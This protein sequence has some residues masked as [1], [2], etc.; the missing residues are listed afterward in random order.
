MQDFFKLLVLFFINELVLFSLL[1]YAHF[2]LYKIYVNYFG[3]FDML[4][5]FKRVFLVLLSFIYLFHSVTNG[6]APTINQLNVTPYFSLN[7]QFVSALKVDTDPK[8]LK[9]AAKYALNSIN[10]NKSFDRRS[11][12]PYS[13]SRNF[14]SLAKVKETLKF[15]IDIIKSDQ[16][17]NS[18]PRVLDP[19]FLN[20]Y[21]KFIKWS[22]DRVSAAKHDK[23]IFNGAVYL[24]H[25]ATFKLP[26]SYTK[27]K[28]YLHALYA[29][30]NKS[31]NNVWIKKLSKQDVLAGKLDTTEYKDKARP[32]FWVS[33]DGLEESL[34]QGSSIIK[35]P[36]GKEFIVSVDKNNGFAYDKTIKDR[37]NQKRYWYF[38]VIP[39][40][41]KFKEY[42]IINLGGA[43]FAGDVYNI[44]FGKIV[45]IR[46]KSKRTGKMEMRLGVI[47]DFGGAFVNNLYQLDFYGGVFNSKGNFYKWVSSMPRNVQAYILVKK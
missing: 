31:G 10:N 14:E 37:K 42:N 39:R 17:L 38:R 12:S 44:G 28:K 3:G 13:F 30:V 8:A 33:R 22:G 47:A 29:L 18:A 35:M 36:D 7:R 27:S 46:Y 41:K 24:T 40:N 23:K 19:L 5:F 34:M 21:F 45:A 25:Y 11:Y 15:I 6:Q 16:R 2:C 4:F 1:F 43:L 32:L 26:G 9:R 20:N